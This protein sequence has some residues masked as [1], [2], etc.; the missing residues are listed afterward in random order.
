MGRFD[1]QPNRSKRLSAPIAARK[2]PHTGDAGYLVRKQGYLAA[3]F[4]KSGVV[5]TIASFNF[6]NIAW[7]KEGLRLGAHAYANPNQSAVDLH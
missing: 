3:K 4:K 2:Q 6:S 5:G 1:P 7:Q